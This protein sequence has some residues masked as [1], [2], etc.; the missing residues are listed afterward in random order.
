M[1]RCRPALLC[2]S[3]RFPFQSLDPSKAKLC[4]PLLSKPFCQ[5]NR[6]IVQH[7][8]NHDYCS[9]Q[10]LFSTPIL[11]LSRSGH[12][13]SLTIGLVFVRSVPFWFRSKILCPPLVL[14]CSKSPAPCFDLRIFDLSLFWSDDI[15][16]PGFDPM[17]EQWGF[18]DHFDPRISIL[19]LFCFEYEGAVEFEEDMK[20]LVIPWLWLKSI[21]PSLCF[22]PR[23]IWGWGSSG[24]LRRIWRR[25]SGTQRSFNVMMIMIGNGIIIKII[26][27][28]GIESNSK[29]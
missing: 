1:A 14:F 21:G 3:D 9:D 8:L 11:Q 12:I 27:F 16:P 29:E 26:M 23:L 22:D 7:C 4:K 25:L 28:S 19:P 2:N 17:R 10:C 13:H 18:E 15:C 24:D 6:P 5:L 20:M